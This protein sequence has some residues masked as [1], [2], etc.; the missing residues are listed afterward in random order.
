MFRENMF[1][2]NTF[3]ANTFRE[4]MFREDMHPPRTNPRPI[5][6]EIDYSCE[7]SHANGSSIIKEKSEKSKK[8]DARGSSARQGDHRSGA[9]QRVGQVNR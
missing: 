5:N 7:L 2:A 8:S 9:L 3:R 4:N 6:I 1:R